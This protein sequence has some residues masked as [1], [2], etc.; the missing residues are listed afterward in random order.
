MTS[1]SR[2]S[3]YLKFAAGI[4][5]AAA[6]AATLYYLYC[7]HLK[8]VRNP[9]HDDENLSSKNTDSLNALAKKLSIPVAAPLWMR[10][11][12]SKPKLVLSISLRNIILWNPSPDRQ[13][14]NYA[15]NEG[16]LPNLKR[17]LAS[18][19][20]DVYL[21]TVVSSDYEEKQI[22]DLL[23]SKEAQLVK[24]GLDVRKVLFCESEKGKKHIVKQ[25]GVD[26]EIDDIEEEKKTP[27]ERNVLTVLVSR[28]N[29][30]KDIEESILPN[31][32]K[33]TEEDNRIIRVRSFGDI[34]FT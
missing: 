12:K 6:S 20:Y 8:F 33:L 27:A 26:I 4:S 7:E 15:F 14:P 34:L 32:F 24:C 22:I 17:L 3:K 5:L 30:T 11:K 23:T 16:I 31:G 19:H 21:I 13:S 29:K 1:R 28:K 2:G 18:Q 9:S 10:F 25:L